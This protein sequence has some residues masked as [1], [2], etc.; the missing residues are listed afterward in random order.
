MSVAYVFGK[1]MLL[2]E[3]SKVPRRS[4]SLILETYGFPLTC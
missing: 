3:S 2:W 1:N 4:D